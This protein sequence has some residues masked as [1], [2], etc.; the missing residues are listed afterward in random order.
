M[1]ILGLKNSL[2]CEGVLQSARSIEAAFAPSALISSLDN[3][4]AEVVASNAA[5]SDAREA[6]MRRSRKL[7]DF[8]DHRADQLLLSSGE[9]GRWFVDQR[10]N[11][12]GQSLAAS[13]VIVSS[14]SDSDLDE[15]HE[16]DEDRDEARERRAEQRERKKEK[17]ER[18]KARA[19]AMLAARPPPPN[20]FVEELAAIVWLPVHAKAPN[21]LLPWKVRLWVGPRRDYGFL[22]GFVAYGATNGEGTCAFLSW[23]ASSVHWTRMSYE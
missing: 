22:C 2:T 8:V 12:S 9:T 17:R 14:E 7:L 20:S 18:Q 3:N 11:S 16:D 5:D 13:Q 1:R 21:D 15:D 10:A 23:G 6:A 4:Q 19:E